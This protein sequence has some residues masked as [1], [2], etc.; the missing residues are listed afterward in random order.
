MSR[1]IEA[2]VAKP[3]PKS[4]RSNAAPS[5]RPYAYPHRACLVRKSRMPSRQTETPAFARLLPLVVTSDSAT[6]CRQAWARAAPSPSP[7]RKNRGP[8][9]AESA[10]AGRAGSLRAPFSCAVL[11]MSWVQ[12]GSGGGVGRRAFG[13]QYNAPSPRCRDMA[14][15]PPLRRPWRLVYTGTLGLTHSPEI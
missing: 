4:S 2:A 8:R 9:R 15:L 14:P 13:P 11:G 10:L 1:Y 7:F 12:G 3:L 6:S 5:M